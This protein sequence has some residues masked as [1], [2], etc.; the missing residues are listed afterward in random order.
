[1]TVPLSDIAV[2]IAAGAAGIL[3]TGGAAMSRLRAARRRIRDLDTALAGTRQHL[4]TAQ[5]ALALRTQEVM[6]LSARAASAESRLERLPEL[7]TDLAH[8]RSECDR[9]RLRVAELQTACAVTETAAAEKLTQLREIQS[10]L[11]ETFRA[12]SAES[13]KENNRAFLELAKTALEKTFA[14]AAADLNQRQT[15]IGDTMK[16]IREVLTQYDRHVREMEMARENAYGRLTRHLNAMA[17]GQQA[18]QRETGRLVKALREPHVR[19]RWG[20]LTLKR[21]AELSGMTERCDF[22]QQQ[23][24]VT[25]DG[26]LR[27]DMV[28]R[29]PGGRQVVVDAKVPLAA[30]LDA[31]DA[32]TPDDRD[33]CMAD[34]ARQVA[35][36]VHKLS[37]KAYWKQFQPSPEFV[38]LFIPGENF[39]SA[40][41]SINP[42][43]IEA[44]AGK[45]VVLATP[46]TLISL[47]KTVAVA[48]GEDAM[49]DNA[50]VISRLGAVLYERLT[51]M[52]RHLSALGQDI[53]R[54]TGS[55]NRLVGSYQRRVMPG[56]RKLE[57]L[58]VAPADTPALPEAEAIADH[59]RILEETD[60]GEEG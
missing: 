15:A 24:A 33:R 21:V 35:T 46:T 27:P 38:V 39:F 58:G 31:L 25:D 10:R 29:L 51:A 49:A 32:E 11:P 8:S 12:V 55:Y 18:L 42:Q 19:G 54:A 26:A 40:A 37:M 13:L 22:L 44:A 1:M 53:K 56:V 20:E 52:H 2:L 3:V 60:H 23:T 41:L 48:W 6:D 47:L 57:D 17:E 34:H 36:H 7:N 30:Y 28:V 59:P 4:E 16:P 45:G 50:R 5:A 43:L 9:L 14:V